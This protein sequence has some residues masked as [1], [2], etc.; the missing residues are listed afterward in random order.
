MWGYIPTHGCL[1]SSLVPFSRALESLLTRMWGNI[2]MLALDTY[3]GVLHYQETGALVEN[4]P[5][6]TNYHV[7]KQFWVVTFFRR[8]WLYRAQLTT[9]VTWPWLSGSLD[10]FPSPILPPVVSIENISQTK[11]LPLN[12]CVRVLLGSGPKLRHRP[13]L[14]LAAFI[15]HISMNMCV[16]MLSCML[17]VHRKEWSQKGKVNFICSLQ[18][19]RYSSSKN[20]Y[21]PF[22][23][24]E[25]WSRPKTENPKLFWQQTEHGRPNTSNGNFEA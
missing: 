20:N 4:T 17:Y 2:K 18:P 3:W 7:E 6:Y 25:K 11:A 12:P 9:E 8:T 14:F 21:Q 13:L 15:R 23:V 10:F 5:A 1:F 22:Q 24:P 19:G 16:T